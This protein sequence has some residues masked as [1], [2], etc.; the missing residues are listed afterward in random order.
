MAVKEHD[1]A[2]YGLHEFSFKGVVWGYISDDSIEWGGDD[3]STNKIWAAQKRNGPWKSLI[4]NPGTDELEGDLI[5]LKPANLKAALGGAVDATNKK[6]SAPAETI[7]EEGPLEI[8]TADGVKFTMP[9]V[10]LVAKP[11]GAFGFT[12]VFKIHFKFTILAPDEKGAAPY[13]I[14]FPDGETVEG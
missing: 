8:T 4:E 7:V 2:I 9:K 3:P 5:E 14:E 12:D 6:W 11:K 13:T 10:S 1:G